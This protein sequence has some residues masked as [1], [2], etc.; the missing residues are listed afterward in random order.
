MNEIFLESIEENMLLFQCPYHLHAVLVHEGQAASGHYWAYVW[1]LTKWLKFN[2][3]SV[4][5]AS[6]DD[7]VKESVG[8]YHNAS[9]YCLMYVDNSK[10]DAEG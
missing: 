8:G 10:L 9:A 3:I 4:T 2:D 5:D 6:W 1:A 7:L